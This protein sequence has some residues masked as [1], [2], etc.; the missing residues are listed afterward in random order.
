VLRDEE[1]PDGTPYERRPRPDLMEI[2]G[3]RLFRGAR[4]GSRQGGNVSVKMPGQF[5][6]C[7]IG[8]L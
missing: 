2:F 5:A 7:A 4:A 8:L 1:T 3:R 6:V